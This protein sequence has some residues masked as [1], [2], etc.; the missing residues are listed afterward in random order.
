T[1]SVLVKVAPEDAFSIF[2]TEIDLWWK[3]GPAYRI[4]GRK[5]GQINFEC[6]PG[7]RLLETFELASGPRTFEVGNILAWEPPQRL[8]FEWRGVNF[9]PDEK[10]TVEVTFQPSASG[11]LV[12]VKHR[13]WSSL[14]D[15][16][17]ARHGLTGREF[18]RM[19]GLWWGELMTS[20][21]EHADDRR[22]G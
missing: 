21:R 22:P 12:T 14:S 4:A 9:K 15:G 20:L 19:I 1:V 13:G 8:A 5:R 6:G 7:G 17:P 10:T 11:T 16:H 3:Q 2:T 18:S